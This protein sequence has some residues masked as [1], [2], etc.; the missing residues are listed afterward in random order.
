MYEFIFLWLSWLLFCF[1]AFFMRRSVY[2]TFYMIGLLMVIILFPY[3]LAINGF[4]FSAGH[5]FILLWC[6]TAII[7]FKL[8]WKNYILIL[9]IA[10][11]YTIYFL[12]RMTSP[13]LDVS[14]FLI[15]A[16]LASMGINQLIKASMHHKVYIWLSGMSYGH[17]LYTLICHSYHLQELK[18]HTYYFVLLSAILLIFAIQTAWKSWQLKIENWVQLIEKKKRWN[19]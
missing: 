15:I 2:R 16:I 3:Y 9:F 5:L 1:P 10:Y 14:T 7:K 12:W 4:L 17:L 8:S 18:H 19:A 11:I 6:T 13:I